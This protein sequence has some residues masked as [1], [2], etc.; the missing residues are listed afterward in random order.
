[1]L[2]LSSRINCIP[3]ITSGMNDHFTTVTGQMSAIS[4]H[5]SSMEQQVGRMVASV[6]NPF[7]P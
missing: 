3:E 2:T 7:M 4:V 5:V 6:M 1:L